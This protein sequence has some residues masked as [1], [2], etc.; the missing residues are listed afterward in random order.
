MDVYVCMIRGWKKEVWFCGIVVVC[1]FVF[2]DL[3]GYIWSGWYI[4]EGGCVLHLVC[5][6]SFNTTTGASN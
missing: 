2:G 5:S 4:G 1:V 6:S 3:F